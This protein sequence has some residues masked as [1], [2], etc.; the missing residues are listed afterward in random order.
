MVKKKNN[1]NTLYVIIILFVLFLLIM[2][3][4]AWNEGI[5]KN[6]MR[7]IFKENLVV[8]QLIRKYI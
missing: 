7:E 6:V 3:F 5:L 8:Y 2:L 1:I 4:F